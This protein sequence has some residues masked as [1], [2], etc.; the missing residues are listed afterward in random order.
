MKKVIYAL[1]VTV[2]FVFLLGCI[3][4]YDNGSL[5]FGRL[6]ACAAFAITGMC[7]CFRRMEQNN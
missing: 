6:I 3:G 1:A 2:Q 7:L 4:A 5:T